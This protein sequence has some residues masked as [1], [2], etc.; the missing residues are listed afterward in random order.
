[1]VELFVSMDHVLSFIENV[2]NLKEKQ[3]WFLNIIKE[4]LGMIEE[5]GS[6]ILK[7][8]GANVAGSLLWIT[9]RSLLT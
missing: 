2:D 3:E 5:C 6:F 7:Y 9:S 1:M 8:L 4:T